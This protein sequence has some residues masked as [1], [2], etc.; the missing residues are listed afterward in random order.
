[1]RSSRSHL[2]ARRAFVPLGVPVPFCT[3]ITLIMRNGAN[4]HGKGVYLPSS[5]LMRR[6]GGGAA[7]TLVNEKQVSRG[8]FGRVQD[9]KILLAEQIPIRQPMGGDQIPPGAVS[10]TIW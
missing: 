9:P 4:R 3:I 1:M 10:F 8:C 2:A 6:G 7:N 5:S